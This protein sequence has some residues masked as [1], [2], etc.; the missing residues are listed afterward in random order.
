MEERQ[1]ASLLKDCGDT[2]LNLCLSAAEAAMSSAEFD[3]AERLY[4][5]GLNWSERRFGAQ[6]AAVGLVLMSM[7]KLYEMDGK[8]RDTRAMEVRCRQIFKRYFFKA[9][10]ASMADC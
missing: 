3:D 1:F 10:S 4:R 2:N 5:R 9:I 8:N 7:I 6:S